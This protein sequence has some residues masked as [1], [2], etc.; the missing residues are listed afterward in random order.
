MVAPVPDH[1]MEKI[2]REQSLRCLAWNGVG[3]R[4]LGVSRCALLRGPEAAA[5]DL[6]QGPMFSECL[7]SAQE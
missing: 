2:A 6:G 3:G 7:S 4:E 1:E 5:L